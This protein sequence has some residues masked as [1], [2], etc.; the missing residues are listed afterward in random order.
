MRHIIYSLALAGIGASAALANS[1]SAMPVATITLKD[2]HYTPDVITVPAGQKIRIEV[3]NRDATADD[4]DSDDLHVDRDMKPHE[5]VTFVV[6]PLKAGHYRFKGELYA[7]T[8][9]G[10]V[11]AVAPA[12]N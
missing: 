10:E 7:A 8:A 9:H 11:I 1:P 5:R 4:F 12:S 3:T 2:H 6:G